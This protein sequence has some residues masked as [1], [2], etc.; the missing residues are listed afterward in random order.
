MSEE[1]PRVF[2][3]EFKV[4]LIARVEAGEDVAKVA[5]EAGVARKLLYDWRKA[6]S[7]PVWW[8]SSDGASRS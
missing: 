1:S 3:T 6:W 2:S 5:R 8:C 4:A 7:C